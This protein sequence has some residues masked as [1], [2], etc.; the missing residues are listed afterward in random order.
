LEEKWGRSRGGAT[1]PE[2]DDTMKSGTVAREVAAADIWR[3]KMTKEN[4]V[5]EPNARLNQTAICTRKNMPESMRCVRKIGE[6]IL[7]GQNRKEKRNK[8]MQGFFMC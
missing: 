2:A 1:V 3:S 8:N 5:A 6:G 4:C 7:T